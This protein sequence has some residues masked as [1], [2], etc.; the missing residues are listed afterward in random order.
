MRDYDLITWILAVCGVPF[1]DAR[2]SSGLP[3]EVCSPL[4]NEGPHWHMF[5]T[6]NGTYIE[7]RIGR[8]CTA[9]RVEERK[10]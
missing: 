1:A 10:S 5:F 4:L 2:D 3:L 8:P 7:H 6:V 9:C